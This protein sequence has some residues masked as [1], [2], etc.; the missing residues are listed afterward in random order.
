[1][2]PPHPARLA[3]MSPR[4]AQTM[5]SGPPSTASFMERELMDPHNVMESG[6]T[7]NGLRDQSLDTTLD[8]LKQ[9]VDMGVRPPAP[10][11]PII[12][13]LPR[14][15]PLTC[16]CVRGQTSIMAVEYDGGVIVGADSRTSTGAP[17]VAPPS[18]AR[19]LPLP[20][21]PPLL[22]TRRRQSGQL[23]TVAL[24]AQACTSPTACRTRLPVWTRGSSFAGRDL[25]RTLRRCPIT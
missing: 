11:R 24:V 9:P 8:F 13:P 2:P 14:P 12:P 19:P 7:L 5:F 20:S 17:A 3:M 10:S 21:P 6:S 1:M 22:D 23:H 25:R 15:T 4:R 18:A 16:L